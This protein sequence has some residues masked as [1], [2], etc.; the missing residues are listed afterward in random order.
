LDLG[1]TAFLVG[2]AFLSAT[3]Y[4]H[5]FVFT[6][7]I[8]ALRNVVQKQITMDENRRKMHDEAHILHR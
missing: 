8:V 4:P 2:G 5:L 3:Y 7:V 6:G 1:L